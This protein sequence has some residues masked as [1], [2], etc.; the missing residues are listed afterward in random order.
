MTTTVDTRLHDFLADRLGSSPKIA[1]LT[2]VGVG[3]SR[4]NWVFDLVHAD[5]EREPLILRRDP[6]GGLVDTDR[7]TEFAV[8]RALEPSRLPAPHARWLDSDGTWLGKPSLIMRREPGECDYRVVNGDRPLAERASL[9]RRFCD[10]LA[11]VHLVD[12]RAGGLGGVLDDPG[13]QAARHELI[14]WETVLR[15]DQLE[16]LPE[17][18]LALGWLRAHAPAAQR[19]V[20]V[21][22]DFK[23]GNILLEGDRV[24]ALLD[25]EL[26]HLGDP[27]EDLG[28]VTQPLRR[29]EHLIDGVWERADLVRR[30]QDVTGTEVD[31][32]ALAWWAAFATFKTAVMQ[33][34]GLRA[35][36]D[37]RSDEPYRPTRKVLG[38]LLAALEERS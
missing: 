23:P 14:R 2:R 5:G 34:S 37:G 4:E 29:R 8:L 6:D 21:H 20:L 17:L 18:D 12:W 36:L 7:G 15:Q 31:E 35:F 13:E 9:A 19:T 3:R 24:T 28:W 10:L 32:T 26:A 22:A 38:T 27:L 33:V 11:E 16:A 25:W 1:G 30:Y